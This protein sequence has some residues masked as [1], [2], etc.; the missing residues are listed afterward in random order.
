MSN[1]ATLYRAA[2]LPG[3]DLANATV[4]AQFPNGRGTPL[5]L[6]L[7]SNGTLANKRF[8]VVVAGTVSSTIT[9]TFTLGVYFGFSPTILSNTQLITTGPLSTASGSNFEL[10]ITL[11]WTTGANTITGS[12]TGMLANSPIGQ[13][14]INT[15]ITSADPNR[16]SNTFLQS[17]AS[18]GF[19]V[20]GFFGTGNA[21]NHATVNIF[22]L[23]TL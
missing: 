14:N 13:A 7:P 18:Y 8:N 12:A 21:S 3:N 2:F 11:Y 6:P 4:E 9:N 22:D 17:G 10:T 20:T 5:I 23:E 19:T 15:P 1:S 16:D